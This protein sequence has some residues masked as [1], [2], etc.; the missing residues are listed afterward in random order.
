MPGGSERFGWCCA[1]HLEEGR[2]SGGAEE[3]HW[4][5][6][7]AWPGSRS[8]PSGGA[9]GLAGGSGSPVV[10]GTT[11][12]GPTCCSKSHL[13]EERGTELRRTMT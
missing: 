2:S 11:G 4:R 12:S 8:F 7:G 9:L 6:E 10:G 13:L 3:N 1:R 5:A